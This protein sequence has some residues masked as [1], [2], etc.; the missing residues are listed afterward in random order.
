MM[1][2]ETIAD[3]SIALHFPNPW[4]GY[5]APLKYDLLKP[6]T[7]QGISNNKQ[8]KN[9]V[10]IVLLICFGGCLSF[11]NILYTGKVDVVD[12]NYIFKG[13]VVTNNLV[14]IIDS[15]LISFEGMFME[16][17][18]TPSSDC[19]DLIWH[20]KVNKK[21]LALDTFY[22][23]HEKLL[24]T[25]SNEQGEYQLEIPYSIINNTLYCKKTGG[26]P[27]YSYLRIVF[28]KEGYRGVVL[29]F[30]PECEEVMEELKLVRMFI[31][32]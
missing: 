31:E 28:Q 30:S 3:E 10:L 4:G 5:P 9:L 18:L 20:C 27:R 12:S 15:V 1:Y 7:K 2:L 22:R 6:Y 21:R 32:Q 24:E 8:M 19:K 17:P 11:Q 23:S 14:T 13:K 29:P 25:Y 16:I 26:K